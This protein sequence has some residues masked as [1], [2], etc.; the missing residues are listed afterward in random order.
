MKEIIIKLTFDETWND[1]KEQNITD[2][3]Y[4]LDAIRDLAPGVLW[5]IQRQPETKVYVTPMQFSQDEC[6]HQCWERGRCEDCG[7][8]PQEEEGYGQ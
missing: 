2:D 8:T 3:F 5:Q 6:K 7:Y 1:Y 4:V